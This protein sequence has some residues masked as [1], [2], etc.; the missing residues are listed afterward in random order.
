MI[1]TTED[2]GLFRPAITS[3][4]SDGLGRFAMGYVRPFIDSSPRV[5]GAKDVIAPSN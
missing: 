4:Q 1:Q 5:V 2:I 3:S